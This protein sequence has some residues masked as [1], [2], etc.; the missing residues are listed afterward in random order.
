MHAYDT[1]LCPYLH[2]AETAPFPEVVHQVYEAKLRHNVGDKLAARV[3]ALIQVHI[4]VFH[5]D[6]VLDLEEFQGLLET[7]EVGQ[8]G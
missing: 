6:R 7:R 1:Y 5:Q 8:C 3:S 4:Q 2:M